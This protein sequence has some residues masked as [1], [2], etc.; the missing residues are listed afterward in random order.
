MVSEAPDAGIVLPMVNFCH[1][2]SVLDEGR[3]GSISH[4]VAVLSVASSSG[5][6]SIRRQ[7]SLSDGDLPHRT[8]VIARGRI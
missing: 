5:E 2:S 7:A 1:D 6:V 4:G 8:L 3:E